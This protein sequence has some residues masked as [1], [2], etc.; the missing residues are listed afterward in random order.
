MEKRREWGE[1]ERE[2]GRGREGREE[3]DKG[4]RE[5]KKEGVG[6]VLIARALMNMHLHR[7]PK[8][9]LGSI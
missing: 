5:E 9:F 1:E 8:C 4:E 6:G 7:H 3:E 2:G